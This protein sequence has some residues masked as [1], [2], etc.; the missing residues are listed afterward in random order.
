MMGKVEVNDPPRKG[1]IRMIAGGPIGGDSQRTGKAQ[2]REAYG[3][4]I[5]EIM[6]VE[7]ANDAPLIRFD[8]E[9]QSGPR[10]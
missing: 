2:V 3:T 4:T 1:V 10:I 9:K 5:K 7:P 8:Q 6:D